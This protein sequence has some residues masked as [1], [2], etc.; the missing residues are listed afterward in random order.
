M[1]G[2]VS[3][4]CEQRQKTFDLPHMRGGVSGTKGTGDNLHS[5]SPHAWGCFPEWRDGVCIV[6][7]FPTCVGVFLHRVGVDRCSIDLPHMRGGVSRPRATSRA[8]HGSSP[9]AWGCF[10]VETPDRRSSSIFPTCVGVFLCSAVVTTTTPNLPHMRGGVSQAS[11]Y[12]QALSPSS[13]HAW[14]CFH[15]NHLSS[16]RRRHLPHMRGGV[17]LMPTIRKFFIWIF[18]T[19]VGVF[20]HPHMTPF[21]RLYLP[22]MRGGVSC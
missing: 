6:R 11:W 2:G 8:D 10:H 7:I 15:E 1:R 19:C 17:S 4:M 21:F 3:C 18:P 22:H 20:P 12:L 5:S 9:H 13:P 14:G 16:A